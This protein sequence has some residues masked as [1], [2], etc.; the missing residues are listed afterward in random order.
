MSRSR[1]SA[2]GW[3]G[4]PPGAAGRYL[5]TNPVLVQVDVIDVEGRL[6]YAKHP[7]WSSADH[8][9]SRVAPSVAPGR[10]AKR[11]HTTAV[12]IQ[13]IRGAAGDLCPRLA[14]RWG[15]VL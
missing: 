4:R 3:P 13:A 9:S 15:S 2:P 1:S 11:P 10:H 12:R 7:A 14:Q 8:R 6:G 5:G